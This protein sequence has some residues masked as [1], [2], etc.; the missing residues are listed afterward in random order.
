MRRLCF[1]AAALS[2]VALPV[3]AQQA[4]PSAAPIDWNAVRDETVDKMREYFR[5]NTTNPAIKGDSVYAWT[6]P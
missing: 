2:L 1:F 4:A 6:L 3:R 5:I